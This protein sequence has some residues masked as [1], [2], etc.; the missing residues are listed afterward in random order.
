MDLLASEQAVE[1]AATVN[2][3][4]H[5]TLD[6]YG[7]D[8]ERLNDGELIR[9]VLLQLC[10]RIGMHALAP[11]LLASAPDNQLKDPGGWSGVLLIA[12]SHITIH[13]FPRRRFLTSDVYSCKSGM[14]LEAI[15][16]LLTT[17]F[18]L[19]ET[20]TNFLRRGLRYPAWNLV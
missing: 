12:E 9:T 20:E 17:R 3:G 15:R 19:A 13:T 1:A 16:S 8:P 6:G 5:Y 2:F 18:G 14:D 7:G 10:E 4:E 11:P